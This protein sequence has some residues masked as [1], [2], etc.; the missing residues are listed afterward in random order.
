MSDD[1]VLE[2]GAVDAGVLA[3]LLARYGLAL[4]WVDDGDDARRWLV[5]EGLIDARASGVAR[6]K[7][8]A[9][10]DSTN[11]DATRVALVTG[12]SRGIGRAI[13][14]ALLE[15]GWKVHFCARTQESVARALTELQ[16]Y[17]GRVYGR[18]VDVGDQAQVDAFVAGVLAAEGA[19]GCLVNNAG[20][21][22]FAPVDELTGDDWRRLIDTNLSGPF[23]F[24]RAVAP[25]MRRQGHGYIVNVASMA[26]RHAMAGGA[27][28]NAGKFGLM[29]LTE[30]AML[31]LRKDGVRVAAVLPG[32]V[33][34]GFARATEDDGWKLRPEDVA[35]TVVDLLAYPERALPSVVEIRPTLTAAMHRQ[36]KANS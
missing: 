26:G 35:R 24:I 27:A 34:T 36:L 12:G 14:D 8:G 30:A 10:T 22:H 32:S 23:Y 31:D 28:Y 3:G 5:D 1:G 4:S 17:G 29:G 15:R 7:I 6:E 18:A 13:V 20:I 11:D 2:C 19:V 33:D 16:R 9:M 21:G 25:V